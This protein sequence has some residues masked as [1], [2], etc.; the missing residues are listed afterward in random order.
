ME[1]L[2]AEIISS[3]TVSPD[4]LTIIATPD[5]LLARPEVAA[6]IGE[7]TGKQVRTGTAIELRVHYELEVRPLSDGARWLYILTDPQ[8]MLPDIARDAQRGSVSCRDIFCNF[9]DLYTV[10]RLDS[11]TLDWLLGKKLQGRVTAERLRWMLEN[12]DSRA[13]EAPKRFGNPAQML[14][15]LTLDWSDTVTI[16]TI[17]DIFCQAVKEGKWPE[18]ETK[19][20]EINF[21][22]YHYLQETYFNAL[23]SSPYLAPKSVKGI[24]P[25]IKANCR[26]DERIALVVVDGMAFWQYTILKAELEKLRV[27]PKEERWV[28]AWIPSITMLSR[29][30]IFR[31]DTPLMEG[32]TQSP[33]SERRLW[34][35]HWDAAQYAPRY[36]YDG[37]DVQVPASCRRLALVTVELD[38]KMHSSSTYQDLL[39]LTENW[40]PDFAAKLAAIKSQ[41][42]TILLTTDHGNV[43]ATGLRN[44][45]TREKQY[46][47]AD[48]SRGHRHAIFRHPEAAQRFASGMYASNMLH[49]DLW[50][51]LADNSSFNREGTHE[52]THGGAHLFEAMIPYIKF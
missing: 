8:Q 49:R 1:H 21:D 5:G 25:Y 6:A 9:N 51:A 12:K 34:T 48:G 3:I 45:T 15:Q 39:D 40:A 7:A 52:I 4:R 33:A 44:F 24:V 18:I 38:K 2:L 10:A 50:F 35:D 36:L 27:H 43:L 26:A 41:G 23:N 47:Y 11:E 14:S 46:L 30:A 29:Q 22:F 19:I 20:G 42:F 13:A 16:L 17:S 28:Y 32:Y 31:G 37:D